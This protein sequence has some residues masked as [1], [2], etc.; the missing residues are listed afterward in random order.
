MLVV[1]FLVCVCVGC[2]LLSDICRSVCVLSVVDCVLL[3]FAVCLLVGGCGG[4]SRA[5]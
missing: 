4:L 1:C 3:V 2:C 5:W